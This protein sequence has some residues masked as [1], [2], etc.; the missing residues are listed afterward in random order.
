[1]RHRSTPSIGAH[2]TTLPRPRGGTRSRGGARADARGGDG[3][4]RPGLRAPR[5]TPPPAGRCV[6]TAPRSPPT[7]P[8]GEVSREVQVPQVSKVPQVSRHRS[9]RWHRCH[10][11]HRW[12]R[13]HSGHRCHRCHRCRWTLWGCAREGLI[14]GDQGDHV[15]SPQSRAA[16]HPNE[17]PLKAR[18]T[19][20][21]GNQ[22]IQRQSL[23]TQGVIHGNQR[24]AW[25]RSPFDL[26]VLT[27][28]S[29][30]CA[31]CSVA[32]TT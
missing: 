19:A 6:A 11:R 20:I 27:S 17:W 18:S 26:R 25:A 2:D 5:P 8:P 32:C 24:Q 4:R 12:H 15:G 14:K 3:A 23:A 31:A 16:R 21:K 22:M 30:Y 9:H 13:C 7:R 1:M 29:R 10:R 28:C